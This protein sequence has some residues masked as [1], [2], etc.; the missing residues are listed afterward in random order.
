MIM[1]FYSINSFIIILFY[2]KKILKDKIIKKYF[3]VIFVMR[4]YVSE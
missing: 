3:D 4:M 1:C 2:A